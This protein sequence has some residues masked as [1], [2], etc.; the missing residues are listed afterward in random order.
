M[1]SC[2]AHVLVSGTRHLGRGCVALHVEGRSL[3]IS[4]ISCDDSAAVKD[5]LF[6]AFL[7][8]RVCHLRLGVMTPKGGFDEWLLS[9]T[10]GCPTVVMR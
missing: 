2:G 7:L 4:H 3:A 10:A 9:A 1:E 5:E 8:M 6:T